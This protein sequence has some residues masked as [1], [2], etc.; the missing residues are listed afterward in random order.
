MNTVIQ[1]GEG[2]LRGQLEAFKGLAMASAPVRRM[3]K[4]W[5]A[6]RVEIRALDDAAQAFV[7]RASEGEL[8]GPEPVGG[9]RAD[10]VIAA[11]LAVLGDVFC[12]RRNPARAHLDG[13]LQAHGAQRDQL[14]LDALVMMIWGA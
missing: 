12:G 11:P 8:H 6:K 5:G 3:L 10:M 4:R 2:S 13:D 9:G 1:G 7:L 14:V